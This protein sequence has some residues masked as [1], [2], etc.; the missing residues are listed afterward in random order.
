[1]RAT[2]S[3]LALAT[4][5]TA[6]PFVPAAGSPDA[7]GIT[8]CVAAAAT[9]SN[10]LDQSDLQVAE[11]AIRC[12]V[13]QYPSTPIRDVALVQA[14]PSEIVASVGAVRLTFTDG[15][16]ASVVSAGEGYEN[17]QCSAWAD[18]GYVAPCEDG[19]LLGDRYSSAPTVDMPVRCL[20]F[21]DTG[22]DV[23]ADGDDDYFL[24]RSTV[25]VTPGACS[26][27]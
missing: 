13:R 14:G 17:P 12:I 26:T 20:R 24:V 9:T 25:M 8:P 11:P 6:L 10:E 5:T 3:L 7:V 27:P 22:I 23:N 18:V 1:M 21:A 15:N 2:R 19:A 16:R 4:L